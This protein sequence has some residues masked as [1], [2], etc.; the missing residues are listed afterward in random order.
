VDVHARFLCC[1]PLTIVGGGREAWSVWRRGS[2][3]KVWARGACPT[4]VP[5][6]STSPLDAMSAAEEAPVRRL[7]LATA[8]ALFPVFALPGIYAFFSIKDVM[9]AWLTHP[10]QYVWVLF[11]CRLLLQMLVGSHRFGDSSICLLPNGVLVPF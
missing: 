9:P 11:A 5:G 2:R 3:E 10:S 6:P 7:R 8:Y 1:C 4:W